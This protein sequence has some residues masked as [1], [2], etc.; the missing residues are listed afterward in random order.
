MTAEARERENNI[1]KTYQNYINAAMYTAAASIIAIITK[2]YTY[3]YKIIV[4]KRLNIFI[5]NN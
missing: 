5:H 2:Q 3:I 4:K 1:T